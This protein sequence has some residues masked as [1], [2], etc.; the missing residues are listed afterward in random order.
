M[1]V[2]CAVCVI[3]GE[4]ADWSTAKQIL[5]DPNFITRLINFN[6]ESVD[7]KCYTKFRQYSKNA[8]F[9]PE[10][11][12]KV[13]KACE[14]LCIWV[15]AVEK[16]HQVYRTV[17]P[18]EKKVKEANEALEIIR[19]GLE[20]KQTMLVKIETHL[21]QFQ[22]QYQSSVEEKKKLENRK[23]LMRSRMNRALE[24]TSALDTEKVRWSEQYENLKLHSSFII[25][26]S[27]L[28]AAS[29]NYLGALSQD[30]REKLI[31]SWIDYFET[32]LDLKVTKNFQI[33]K[34]VVEKTT[35]RT[36]IN[37]KLPDDQ[38]SIENAIFLKN[39]IKWPLII[40]PQNQAMQWI[41]EME[42]H[43]LKMCK[44]DDALVLRT[45]EQAIRLGQ[46]ILIDN[47]TENLDPI[48]DN[49]LK[50]EIIMRGGQKCVKL[51]DLEVEYNDSFRL[52]LVTSLP[53]PHYLPSAYIKVNLINFTITFKCLYEQLLSLVV[54]RE[55]PELERERTNLL[56]TISKDSLTLRELEDK[57]LNIL[58]SSSNNSSN[59]TGSLDNKKSSK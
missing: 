5:N 25:G 41:R 35:I 51:G 8:D 31:K 20:K 16:F 32:N 58:S 10:I 17:K 40:D 34:D 23:E 12:G 18:K 33:A 45:L 9:Q 21:N 38:Y 7:E 1:T 6:A 30:Y 44:M 43:S 59:S 42:G 28:S 53:N 52:Y 56:E 27:I 47:L 14:S 29:V 4:K 2:M 3:L 37:Q 57:A 19:A 15:L 55:R 11:V 46:P 26:D 24:L 36:W 13:S 50:K 49:V 48:L 54:L 22:M 39:S